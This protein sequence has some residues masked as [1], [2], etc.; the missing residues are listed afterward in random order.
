LLPSPISPTA[1]PLSPLILSQDYFSIHQF[2]P[3]LASISIQSLL[4]LSQFVLSI[5]QVLLPSFSS[6]P[7]PQHLHMSQSIAVPS[8]A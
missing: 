6:S 3:T 8:I 7:N 1:L 2:L 4:S 5:K